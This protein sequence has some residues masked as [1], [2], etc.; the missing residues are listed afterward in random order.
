MGG[1]KDHGFRFCS[2][3][4]HAQKAGLIKLL[5]AVPTA[6]VDAESARI[7]NGACARCGR[8]GNVEFHRSMFVW[9]AVIYTRMSERTFIAC[10]TCALK[11]QAKAT[12]GTLLAGWWGFPFGLLYT[13]A[14]LC[15]NAYQM[16]LSG[17]RKHA[18][19]SLRDHA[20]ERLALDVRPPGNIPV[21]VGAIASMVPDN[22]DR[23]R[24][25]S[26]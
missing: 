2:K 20:R 10:T 9:S 14:A 17:N 1:V 21:A 12:A 5:A 15:A 22:D 8:V 4:C 23:W 19:A 24:R 16:L 3:A 11:A 18:S 26:A 6:S 25:P 7:R 13:P